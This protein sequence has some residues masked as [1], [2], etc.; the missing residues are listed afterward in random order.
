MIGKKLIEKKNTQ[1][2][3]RMKRKKNKG[4]VKET[5]ECHHSRK[6][7]KHRCGVCLAGE[8]HPQNYENVENFFF[9]NK[10]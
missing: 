1:R 6:F 4:H 10:F 7:K 5:A 8:R 2:K 9:G 3:A